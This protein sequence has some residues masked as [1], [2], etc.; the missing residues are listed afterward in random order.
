MKEPFYIL[1]LDDKFY[2]ADFWR[3]N[4][5]ENY[6]HKIKIR[7]PFPEMNFKTENLLENFDLNGYEPLMVL[8]KKEFYINGE[9]KEFKEK[10]NK[11]S[12]IVHS[13]LNKIK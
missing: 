12:N 11:H 4:K 10:C 5:P 13:R 3:H 1:K 2:N 6:G 8:G 7:T 9:F